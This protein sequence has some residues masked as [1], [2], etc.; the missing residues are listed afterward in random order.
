MANLRA[1][2]LTGTGGRNAIDGSVYFSGYVDGASSDYLYI[3]DS[4][5]LDMGTGDFSFE[6]W[7]KSVSHAGTSTPNT[8]GIISSWSYAAGGILIQS[9]NTGPLRIVI[10]LSGGGYLD[11][12]GTTNLL[13]TW[14]HIAVERS[15]GTLKGYVNGIEEISTSYAVGVD[16]ALG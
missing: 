12:V 6:C 14:N 15:S 8:M 1:D 4:D 10:P 5:D 16:F 9:R 13:D 7:L 11:V 2:N 3:P